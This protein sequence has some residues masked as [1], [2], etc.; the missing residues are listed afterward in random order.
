MRIVVV[1]PWTR[2]S[3]PE[4]EE[5]H[6]RA[7]V[8]AAAAPGTTIDF[9][10]IDESS[11]FS[12]PFSNRNTS[13]VVGEIVQAI[14]RAARDGPGAI[15]VWGGLDPGVG[16]A[17]QRVRVPVIGVA[18]ATYAA[19]AQLGVRLGLVVYEPAIVDAIVDAARACRAEHLIAGIRSIDVPMPE[20]TPRRGDVRERLVE[21]AGA[22]LAQDGATAI[23][24]NGMSMMPAAMSADELASRIG[25]PVLDP[26]SIGMRTA[27][28]IAELRSHR[29]R[30][31]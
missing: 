19:A 3:L 20:L 1:F 4:A 29:H 14:E 28:M 8:T 18:Q 15:L 24:V 30:P 22:A 11:M 2:G 23:Y 16:L 9:V 31:G 6:R 5:A 12:E 21:V 25:A 17:R 27:E 13:R 10:Q 7:L 26:L